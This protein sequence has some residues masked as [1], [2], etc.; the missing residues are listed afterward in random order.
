MKIPNWINT[1]I[2]AAIYYICFVA[3]IILFS[4]IYRL[5]GNLF[6]LFAGLSI[7]A[8]VI[9]GHIGSTLYSRR[10]HDVCVAVCSMT[11][12]VIA[13]SILGSQNAT[14]DAVASGYNLAIPVT[15]V[16]VWL[17]ARRNGKT[18]KAL[19]EECE[20]LQEAREREKAYFD[21]QLEMKDRKIVELMQ[22][23]SEKT[24]E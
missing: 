23:I 7:P 5:G 13:F 22:R 3:C 24:G 12:L 6:E 15:F 2:T 1:M 14:G 19:E 9:A 8:A 17:A 16:C 20:R 4:A 11:F 10:R 21:G 18:I